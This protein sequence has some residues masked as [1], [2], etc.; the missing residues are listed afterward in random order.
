MY[1]Y[2]CVVHVCLTG[3]DKCVVW[4][5]A[6]FQGGARQGLLSGV[7]GLVSPGEGLRL[8]VSEM[9]RG[10]TRAREAKEGGEEIN[11]RLTVTR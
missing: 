6:C 9:E 5:D 8:P 1:K 7:C 2:K 10:R 11:G 3:H 4:G